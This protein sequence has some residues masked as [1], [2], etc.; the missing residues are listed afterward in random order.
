M[1]GL[2]TLD[3][4]GW[5][6]KQRAPAS[7]GPHPMLLLLHG[8]TGDENAM[9]V[10]SARFPRDWWLVAPRGPYPAPFGG[11]GWQPRLAEEWPRVEDFRPA[12]EAL[13]ELL[14]PQN[15]PTADG[16]QVHLA[17]FSQGAALA[18]SLAL[19]YPGRVRSLAGLSGFM[20]AGAERLAAAAPLRG[21]AAFLAHG[22]Q[23][24]LVPVERARQARDIL[25]SA[26][27]QVFYCE[28]DVGHKLA[29]ACFRGL[30]E[31]FKFAAVYS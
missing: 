5:V 29:A 2:E 17:G 19:L 6:V 8:W 9:W 30:G 21:K 16:S 15:F 28:E 26:G 11:Y 3:I 20:P 10:F 27:A 7:P 12:A 23:D 1:E 22:L 25:Q 14:R 31:F 18:Y 13:L 4:N 24:D